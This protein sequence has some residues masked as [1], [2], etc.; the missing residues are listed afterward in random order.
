[1]ELGQVIELQMIVE[2]RRLQ[3]YTFTE[4]NKRGLVTKSGSSSLCKNLLDG[5]TGFVVVSADIDKAPVDFP[6]Q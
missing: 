6:K 4:L 3:T 1:L 5:R 2:E